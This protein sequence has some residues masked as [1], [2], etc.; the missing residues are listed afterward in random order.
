M[1]LVALGGDIADHHPRWRHLPEGGAV[2]YVVK[3]TRYLEGLLGVVRRA[4][5]KVSGQG[6]LETVGGTCV[7]CSYRHGEGLPSQLHRLTAGR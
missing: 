3:R 4:L 7:R 5:K 2:D 6:S 1:R